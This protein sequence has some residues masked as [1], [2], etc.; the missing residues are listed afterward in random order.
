MMFRAPLLASLMILS[1]MVGPLQAAAQSPIRGGNIDGDMFD[2]ETDGERLQY[3]KGLG[4]NAVRL[5]YYNYDAA[6]DNESEWRDWLEDFMYPRL[7]TQV[8]YLANELGLQVIISI[9]I[10]PGGRVNA[11]GPVDRALIPGEETEWM[12]SILV[13]AWAHIAEEFNSYGDKVA[14]HLY[15]EPAPPSDKSAWL[16]LQKQIIDAIR[17]ADDTPVDQQPLIYYMTEFGAP[18]NFKSVNLLARRGPMGL[19]FGAYF[20]HDYTHQ[21]LNGSLQRINYPGCG[22]VGKRA[23]KKT[24]AKA[25]ACSAPGLDDSVKQF[26]R[27]ADKNNLTK[28]AAELSV[29]RFAPNAPRF[30]NDLLKSL[31][32]KQISWMYYYL[33]DKGDSLWRLDCKD[34]NSV[35]CIPTEPGERSSRQIAVERGLSNLNGL[36]N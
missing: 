25:K 15:S 17:D 19:S 13:E 34:S 11:P 29:S 5:F 9:H 32:K 27:F 36:K 4:M 30:L 10:P 23:P 35:E 14:Y 31:R 24:S 28:L 21:G 18:G 20:P 33:N 2:P 6:T 22:I 3:F 26:A 8:D 16:S 7:A 1:M 12:R